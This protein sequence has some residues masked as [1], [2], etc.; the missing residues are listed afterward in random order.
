MDP[1]EFWIFLLWMLNLSQVLLCDK[2]VQLSKDHDE[3]IK[4]FGHYELVVPKLVNHRGD[5]LSFDLINSRK[6]TRRHLDSGY[7]PVVDK[8]IHYSVQAYDTHFH[9]NLT[10]NTKLISPHFVVEREDRTGVISR[11]RYVD[12]CHYTGHL[13]GHRISRVAI[14]NCQGL[15]GLMRTADEEYFIEPLEQ[16]SSINLYSEGHPHIVYKRSSLPRPANSHD[17]HGHDKDHKN[18]RNYT[19]EVKEDKELDDKDKPWWMSNSDFEFAKEVDEA[20]REG[21]SR[22]RRLK[23]VSSVSTERNVETLIVAEKQMISFHTDERIEAYLLTIM[24]IVEDLYHDASIGNYINIVVSKMRLLLEEQDDVTLNFHAGRSLD[25]F[26]EWQ[27]AINTPINETNEFGLG[28][29]DNAVLITRYD[30]CYESNTPCQTIGLAL[31]GAMCNPSRSCNINQDTGLATAFTVAHEIGH[32]FG[33]KHDG[34]GNACGTAGGIMAGTYTQKTDFYSWSPC[35]EDYITQFIDAGRAQCLDNDPHQEVRP[36]DHDH[37]AQPGQLVGG[38]RQCHYQIGND[39]AVACNFSNICSE[40][41]CRMPG[42]TTCVG[43]SVPAAEGTACQ[44]S[45]IPDGWCYMMQCVERGSRP[46]A[47]DGGWGSWQTWSDCSRTCGGGVSRSERHCDNPRPS[48]RGQYCTGERIRYRSCNKQDCP[49]DSIDFHSLQCA[50]LNDEPYEE[51]YYKWTPLDKNLVKPCELICV[52]TTG[53]HSKQIPQ[54]EDGTRCFSEKLRPN[55]YDVCINGVCKQVGCDKELGSEVMEDKCRICGGDGSTCETV[56]GSYTGPLPLSTYQEIVTIPTGATHIRVEE[57]EISNNYLAL[58]SVGDVYH[59]NAEW[60]IE[61]PK[62]FDV[63]GTTF[64]YDRPEDSPETLTALGPTTEELVVMLLVQDDSTGVRF[65]FNRPVVRTNFGDEEVVFAWQRAP[66]SEC[67]RSCAGG[68]TVSAVHCIRYD[69]NSVVSDHYC[70]VN[71]KP[72]HKT[73]ECNLEDCP[74]QWSVGP[75]SQCTR[76]CGGGTRTRDV[77]CTIWIYP[78]A[79]EIV[80]ESYCQGH[81]HRSIDDCGQEDCPPRWV[82]GDWSRCLPTCGPGRKTRSVSCESHNGNFR[83]SDSMCDRSKK[84]AVHMLCTN[85]DCPP[86]SWK[87]GHWSECSAKCGQGSIDREV[88]CHAFMGNMLHE[89]YCD[90]SSKP[91]SSRPCTRTCD[92]VVVADSCIDDPSVQYCPLVKK[93]SFCANDYFNRICCRTCSELGE[94]SL[95]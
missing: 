14:S 69:D 88:Y 23:R 40:L 15:H 89:D 8:V 94:T 7:E 79:Q 82:V 80:D 18:Y 86:P 58:K 47:V 71:Q 20:R 81:K 16:Y 13:F 55:I 70:D 90:A 33:M 36:P 75:W 60:F 48:H 22:H 76:S 85:P 37:D 30:I 91:A 21:R 45:N 56:A 95:E 43:T 78:G 93:F 62:S 72:E 19:C 67:S 42:Q 53:G 2:Y 28:H 10:L 12:D 77:H 34:D 57:A 38:N 3:M 31:L 83:Y 41:A 66:W 6:R 46:D 29:H 25:N 49:E 74:P 11:H 52:S 9:M 32:N 65:T 1:N 64:K 73:K 54:V 61:W 35:S 59:I 68:E 27:A 26:C 51:H 50:K 39:G 84:P 44:T 4:K 87:T 5:F 17:H 92:N 63:A 24:N